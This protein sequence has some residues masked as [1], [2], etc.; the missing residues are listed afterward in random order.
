MAR[1]MR[2]MGELRV[3]PCRSRGEAGPLPS[4]MVVTA[5]SLFPSPFWDGEEQAGFGKG[6]QPTWRADQGKLMLA[7]HWELVQSPSC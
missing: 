6:K 4:V 3:S 5:F 7:R 2:E 1:G